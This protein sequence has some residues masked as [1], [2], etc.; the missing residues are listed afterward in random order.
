MKTRHLFAAFCLLVA[1]A[2]HSQSPNIQIGLPLNWPNEPSVCMNPANPD[3]IIIGAVPDNEYISTDGGYTWQHGILNSPYGVNGDP[4]VL[5]D[6][7]GKFYYFHLVQDLSRIV[8]HTKDGVLSPW[9]SESFTANYNDYD[10]DKE[11]A[12]LDPATGNLYASWTRFNTWGSSSPQDSTDI[13]MAK[14]TD[15]GQTWGEQKLISNIGGNATGGFGSVHGSYLATG[16]GGKVYAAWWSPAGLMF[17]RSLDEGDTWLDTD[18]HVT[19]F[20]VQWLVTIPGIQTGVSF[21]VIA[22]DRSNGPHS[23]NIYINWTD[24]RNGAGNADVWIVK[25]TDGG[26]TW[27]APIKVNDDGPGKHQFFNYMT[28]DQVTGK[29]YVIFYDR[30]NYADTR[31]DVYVAISNDGG[32]TFANHRISDTPFVPYSTLF[33]GH[34]IA[35]AAHDDHVFATWMRM[36]EGELSL[37]GARIDPETVGVEKTAAI[38]HSL[39]QNVPNPF[40]ES[41]FFSFKLSERSRVSLVVNDIFGHTVATLI[42][43]ENME[44]GKHI[45]HFSPSDFNLPAGMYH[46]SLITGKK[47]LT[48]KM[49]HAR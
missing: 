6:S 36:D 8:C 31:T 9:S 40:T 28:V 30:R 33:F 18:I 22:A 24:K 42:R 20:P 14:S 16:A 4:V 41:T 10:I 17:D 35:I 45:V 21:P 46:Y 47:T 11:W 39:E 2:A 38:P 12:A 13:F 25:S 27:S 43:D 34:Y 23:G 15:G 49:L 48:R 32:E 19:G 26:D 1:I 5:A 37:W 7:T 3:Q 44:Q 29:I